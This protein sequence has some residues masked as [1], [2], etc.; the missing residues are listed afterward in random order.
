MSHWLQV[1]NTVCFITIMFC[2]FALAWR[3]LNEQ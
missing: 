1:I 3:G 2:I